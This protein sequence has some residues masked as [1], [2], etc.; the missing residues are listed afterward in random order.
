MKTK[1]ILQI[2]L[3]IASTVVLF[4]LFWLLSFIILAIAIIL[5][6]LFEIEPGSLE[7]ILE[8]IYE[9]F[10]VNIFEYRDR[11][12]ENVN[13]NTVVFWIINSILIIVG[14]LWIVIEFD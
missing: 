6:E 13:I 9:F 11:Y 10:R 1:S 2:L 7:K 4:I 8:V 12:Y 3:P 5:F 14:E